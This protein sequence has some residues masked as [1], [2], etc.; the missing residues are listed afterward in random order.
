MAL[1][2]RARFAELRTTWRKLG[3]RLGFGVGVS[4]GYATMGAVGFEGRFDYTANGSVVNLAARLADEAG[5]AQI[6]ISQR[7]NSALDSTVPTES[8]GEL[9]LKG[10]HAPVEVFAVV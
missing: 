6:L 4:F 3:H 1:A 9:Q 8:M 2:M 5:D 10:F 7:A